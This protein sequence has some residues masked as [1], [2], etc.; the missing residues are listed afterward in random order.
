MKNNNPALD[1]SDTIRNLDIS[2]LDDNLLHY[3]YNT[4]YLLSLIEKGIDKDDPHFISSYNGFRGELFENVTYELLL[5]YCLTNS[6]VT[7]FILKGPHQNYINTENQK[8]GLM[9]DRK[10]QIVYKAGYKDVSEYDAMFFTKDEVYFVE[11]TIVVSTIGLRK[12]L[13]KKYALLSLLF[14]NLKIKALIILSEGATGVHKFPEFA[15]VWVTDTL[16]PNLILDQLAMKDKYNKKKLSYYKST[17][18]I[19]TRNIEVEQFKYFD[20]LAWIFKKTLFQNTKMIN[21]KFFRS[22]KVNRYIEIFSKV[23]IGFI[24]FETLEK[25]T[26]TLDLEST[27][28]VYVTIDK[29]DD[30]SFY[31]VFYTRVN[32]KRLTKIEILEKGIKL[33]DKDPKGFTVAEVKFID[34]VVK[35]FNELNLKQVQN[36]QKKVSNWR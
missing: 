30:G 28:N 6:Y 5:Q 35:P 32:K 29:K 17:K 24:S 26:G 3:T 25:L 27:N 10:Q 18:L 8:F 36:I 20:T 9:M 34:Y 16:N 23:Y 19:E 12:R 21:E 33:S 7:S 22:E 1:I 31:V 4:R 15:T 11:A 14:P 2:S 13:R